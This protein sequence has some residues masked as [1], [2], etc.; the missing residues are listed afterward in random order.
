MRIGTV[1]YTDSTVGTM[2]IGTVGK[3]STVTQ[4]ILQFILKLR[5]ILL[6]IYSAIE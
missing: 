4:R 2:R 6:I 5:G 3:I 1:H